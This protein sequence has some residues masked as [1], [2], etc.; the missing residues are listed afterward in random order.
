MCIDVSRISEYVS[1]SIKLLVKQTHSIDLEAFSKRM[2]RMRFKSESG[3][4][5][6]PE[7]LSYSVATIHRNGGV[8]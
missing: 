1:W 8:E 7:N 5:L 3:R 6:L 2:K 4:L